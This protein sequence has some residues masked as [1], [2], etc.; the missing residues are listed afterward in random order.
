MDTGNLMDSLL[1][2]NEPAYIKHFTLF[3]QELW[4]NYGIDAEER[5][6]DIEEGMD[7][8]SEVIRHSD[9]SLN[10]ILDIIEFSSKRNFVYISNPK[11]FYSSTK[12]NRFSY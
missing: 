2:S 8:D 1:V 9:K 4:N 3:F 6:K 5:I 12:G 10:N 11:V 7:Y